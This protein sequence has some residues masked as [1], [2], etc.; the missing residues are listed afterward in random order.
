MQKLFPDVGMDGIL[1]AARGKSKT[2]ATADIEPPAKVKRVLEVMR[3][4]VNKL[5][6]LMTWA[7]SNG[8]R[9]GEFVHASSDTFFNASGLVCD[10]F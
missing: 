10:E 4:L 1:R 9:Y 5:N 3:L 8:G 6:H 7:D 2:G